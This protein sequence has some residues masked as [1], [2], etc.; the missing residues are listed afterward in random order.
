M[1]SPKRPAKKTR[2]GRP[3]ATRRK[4]DAESARHIRELEA[5]IDHLH[6]EIDRRDLAGA[7]PLEGPALLAVGPPG[8]IA[9]EEPAGGKTPV[10]GPVGDVEPF[11]DC[12]EDADFL[13]SS[14]TMQH[15]RQEL[16]RERADRELELADEPFWW[17]CPKCGE[18]L[19]EH[20]FDSIKAERCDS[21]GTLS[22]DRGEIDLLLLC[23]EEDRTLAHRVRGLLQ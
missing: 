21:C 3:A 18:H 7:A 19:S 11:E 5:E 6:A 10:V 12:D 16:D 1:K 4:P 14:Q 17:V 20:E 22:I 13:S 9:D 2:A 15:R 8:P 23:S